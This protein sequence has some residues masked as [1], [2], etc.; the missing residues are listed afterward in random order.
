VGLL[1]VGVSASAHGCRAAHPVRS[2]LRLSR[3]LRRPSHPLCRRAGGFVIIVPVA[4]RPPPNL[5]RLR[6]VGRRHRAPVRPASTP[7]AQAFPVCRPD[8]PH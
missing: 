8:A 5:C 7:I 2:A 6:H 1:A 4:A 3:R